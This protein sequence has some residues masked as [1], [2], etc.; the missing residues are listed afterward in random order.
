[1]LDDADDEDDDAALAD[2]A[3]LKVWS[4]YQR[5]RVT[6]IRLDSIPTAGPAAA[7]ASGTTSDAAA[8]GVLDAAIQGVANFVGVGAS[9]PPPTAAGGATS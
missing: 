7:S 5:W 3:S 2:E 6:K 4:A 1:V 8:P 9:A